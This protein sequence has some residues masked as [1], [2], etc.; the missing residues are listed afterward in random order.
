MKNVFSLL[1]L[2]FIAAVAVIWLSWPDDKLHVIMCDVGQGDALLLTLG[3]QQ[4]LI[5]TGPNQKVLDCLE[6]YLPLW[7]K[8]IEA[9]VITHDDADHAAGVLTI[10]PQYQIGTLFRNQPWELTELGQKL[11][12]SIKNY[13]IETQP[14]TQGQ[15]VTL[16]HQK[17][18]V[19][20]SVVWP[21]KKLL[22]QFQKTETIHN[23]N[24]IL[25]NIVKSI[26][27][28]LSISGF[29]Q[30]G[31]LDIYD[32][33]DLGGEVELSLV[34]GGLTK[35][36][37]VMKVSHHGSKNST[38][39]DFINSISPETALIGVGKNNRY[40]HPSTRVIDLL[41]YSNINILET[42]QYGD[43]EIVADPAT[44]KI[45]SPQE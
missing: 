44:Y 32:G 37:D 9:V 15:V 1:L 41:R 35:D 26:D 11:E 28:D 10:L 31:Q 30:Y 36:V 38:Y 19:R 25:P 6:K 2:C 8:Q 13:Q 22:K 24:L 14:L 29:I 34:K 4:L 12:N 3:F 7:D 21:E 23:P 43:V 17:E 33:G 45:I 18:D 5:D 27:N 20:F 42:S 40:G 16:H 39:D